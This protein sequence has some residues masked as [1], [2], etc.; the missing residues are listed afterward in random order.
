MTPL[1]PRLRRR[2]ALCI[3]FAT[4]TSFAGAQESWPAHPV[5]L[6]VPYAAG[7]TSDLLARYIAQNLTEAWGQPVLV[8]NRTGAGTVIGSST[9][10][11]AKPD[12]YTLLMTNNTHVI[13]PLVMAS[14]PYDPLRDF[15][16]LARLA[17]TPY[18]LLVNPK[19]PATTVQEY[20]ALARSR[21]GKLNFGTGGPGGLTHLGGEIFNAQ[22]KT[23]IAMIHYKGAAPLTA[24][25]LSGEIDAY[26][27]AP[28]TTTQ[29]VEQGKLRALAVTGPQ[30]LPTM[31]Q[32]PTVRESGLPD[33]DVTITYVV[34]G[35]AG[36]PAN[37]R[38]RIGNE[39]TRIL[40]RTDVQQKLQSLGLTPAAAGPRDTA[41][42]LQGEQEKYGRVVKTARIK[43]E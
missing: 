16:P 10:A 1:L 37:V 23:E 33:Y 21:P 15:M 8:E 2:A 11:K 7:G 38:D 32:V 42:W 43:V 39:I 13:N 29:L 34:L 19:V 35:P 14:V 41:S 18:L 27:D 9:V 22:A 31:P 24:A 28:A 25:A 36:L 3:A 26:L 20:V 17:S 40:G 30:R 4:A 12:G 5:K 6:V